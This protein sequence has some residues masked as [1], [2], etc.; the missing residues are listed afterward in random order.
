M[1]SHDAARQYHF[2][3]PNKTL[4]QTENGAAELIGCYRKKES[5]A[6]CV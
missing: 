2:A 5:G 1:R 4:S 3:L 6:E